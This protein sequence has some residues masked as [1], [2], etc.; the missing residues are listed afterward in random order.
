[1]IH[2]LRALAARLRGLFGDRKANQELDDEIETHLRLLTERYVRQGQTEAEAAWAARRQ[3]GNVTL[4]QEANRE[5]RGIKFI[6][7]VI[8][9]LRYG[10]WMLRRNPGFTFVAVLT[11]ALGIGANTAI[12]SVVNAVLLKPLPYYDPQRLCWVTEEFQLFGEENTIDEHYFHWQAQSKTFD[13]L[14]AYHSGNLYLTGRG[15]PERLDYVEATADLFPAE[16]ESIARA[17]GTNPRWGPLQVSV[18]P[19]G[20]RL[21]GH[22]RRG[23]LVQ[24]AAVAFI[25]L[26]ACANVANLM[27]ARARV[28]SFLRARAVEPGYN[29]RNLLTLTIPL[30]FSGYSPAQKKIFYQDLLVMD[31]MSMEQRLAESVAPRRFHMRKLHINW[32]GQFSQFWISTRSFSLRSI[33]RAIAMSGRITINGGVGNP[34]TEITL[35]TRAVERKECQMHKYEAEI[36][37][38]RQGAEFSDSRYSRGHEWSFDGGVKIMASASPL[39]VP[40]PYSVVEAVDP[41]EALVASAAS[42]HMLWFL[43]IAAGRGFVVESYMDKATGIMEKNSEGKIAITRI[44]LRPKI[45]FSADRAPSPEELQSLH[46]SA[47]DKCFIAN[48]LKSE[49]VVEVA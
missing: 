6:E 46:H 27:L 30:S 44:T 24:F 49:V 40:V 35:Q 18:T 8:Q 26:I 41:E 22:L 42:C 36:S 37:W 10:L 34:K 47:H 2:H 17:V 20:E 48:S 5:M 33:E 45:E 43:S 19:L 15:E 13:H 3:F 38:K 16:L 32:T 11:L 1:M 21:V 14:V 29:P 23:L 9:D 31:V 4:L 7:T 25:L 39:S 12:F 28:K